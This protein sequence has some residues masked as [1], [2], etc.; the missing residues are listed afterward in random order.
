GRPADP[1]GG[2]PGRSSG[3]RVR[4]RGCSRLGQGGVE[5]GGGGGSGG[6]GGAGVVVQ[7]GGLA[8]AGVEQVQLAGQDGRLGR[9]GLGGQAGQQVADPLAVGRGGLLGRV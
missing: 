6:G 3:R 1:A 5:E 8:A 7:A 4:P 2:F 9:A